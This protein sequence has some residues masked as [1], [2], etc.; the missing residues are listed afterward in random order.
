MFAPLGFFL[1][2]PVGELLLAFTNDQDNMDEQLLDNLQYLGI[3]GLIILSTTITVSVTM[4][5]FSIFG[6]ILII[7]KSANM[8]FCTS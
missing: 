2:N 7:G 5:Y 3:Y 4:Y 6:G 8:Y 1:T